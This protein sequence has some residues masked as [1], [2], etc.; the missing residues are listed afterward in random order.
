MNKPIYSILQNY[1][2]TFQDKKTIY[3]KSLSLTDLIE[4]LDRNYYIKEIKHL[5]KLPPQIEKYKHYLIR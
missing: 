3:Y 1:K 2:V 5:K 4:K